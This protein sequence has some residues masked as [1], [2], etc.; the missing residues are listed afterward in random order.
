MNTTF[1]QWLFDWRAWCDCVGRAAFAF[2]ILAASIAIP[3]Y[4]RGGGIQT[5][6]PTN[7]DEM[8]DYRKKK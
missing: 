6:A 8:I 7:Y 4:A 2:G 1:F 3:V 5:V